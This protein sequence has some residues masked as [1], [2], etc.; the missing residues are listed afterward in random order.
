MI[1]R[2]GSAV[3]NVVL[4]PSRSADAGG[5]V[6]AEI[7]VVVVVC[8][9]VSVMARAATRATATVA[10]MAVIARVLRVVSGATVDAPIS[11]GCRHV[12]S[13]GGSGALSTGMKL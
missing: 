7:A 6:V 11:E 3:A 9:G 10:P 13:C 12:R 1:V 8:R 5:I 4:P 2:T